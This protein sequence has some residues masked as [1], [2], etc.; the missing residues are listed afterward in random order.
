[1]SIGWNHLPLELREKIF[2]SLSFSDQSHFAL[3]S[4]TSYMYWDTYLNLRTHFRKLTFYFN[5]N[6]EL[7]HHPLMDKCRIPFF[8]FWDF[9]LIPER[10]YHITFE[11]R[12]FEHDNKLYLRDNYS[13]TGAYKMAGNTYNFQSDGQFTNNKLTGLVYFYNVQIDGQYEIPTQLVYLIIDENYTLSLH[14]YW[15]VVTLMEASQALRRKTI[16]YVN[17]DS[18]SLSKVLSLYPGLRPPSSRANVINFI[19]SS[20]NSDKFRFDSNYKL[21]GRNYL[22]NKNGHQYELDYNVSTN[23][24]RDLKTGAVAKPYDSL[25]S[26][27]KRL[28]KFPF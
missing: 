13:I 5:N 11:G 9:N 17:V 18:P 20:L 4:K 22:V 7:R 14:L 2:D 27:A 1:M 8:L 26:E 24:L 6:T 23:M 10:Q 12:I 16:Y 3:T 25:T 21:E 15:A 19:Y 28:Y